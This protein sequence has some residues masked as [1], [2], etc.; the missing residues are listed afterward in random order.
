[1]VTVVKD[2]YVYF[3]TNLYLHNNNYVEYLFMRFVK[4]LPIFLLIVLWF[5]PKLGI[6]SSLSANLKG[7]WLFHQG[8]TVLSLDEIYQT[9]DWQ[10]VSTPGLINFNPANGIYGTYRYNFSLPKGFEHS[11]KPINLL[12][13]GI[14]HSDITHLNGELIGTTGYL[15]KNWD[16]LT[17]TPNNLPRLYS[18]PVGLLKQHNNELIVQIQLGFGQSFGAMLPG[19]VGISGEVNLLEANQAQQV[20]NQ[21]L[22]NIQIIDSLIILLGII[23]LAIILLLFKQTFHKFPEFKWLFL[24][25][26]LLFFGGFLLD[27]GYLQGMTGEPTKL[28]LMLS[29]LLIPLVN[30]IFFDSQQRIVSKNTI[31]FASALVILCIFLILYPQVPAEIKSLAWWF[32]NLLTL[33]FFLFALYSAILNVK[34]KRT[35]GLTMLVGFVIYLS[36]IRTQWLPFDG[37]EHR[38]IVIGSLIFRYALIWAYFLKVKELSFAYQKLS[39]RMIQEI[40]ENKK[41]IA[42]DIHDEL[43]Q[44]LASAKLQQQLVQITDD[45][46]HTVF[47]NEELKNSVQSMRRIIDG[48]HPIVLEKNTFKEALQIEANRLHKLHDIC[49]K[50]EAPE[51]EF[52]EEMNT[53][54][55]RLIQELLSNS[56]NHGQATHA[57][58]NIKIHPRKLKITVTDNG[59]GITKKTKKTQPKS[60]GFGQISLKERVHLLGGEV[61]YDKPVDNKGVKVVVTIPI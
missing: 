48:L 57:A 51:I 23:D 31:I 5:I 10:T 45:D 2:R 59:S 21:K 14:R 22:T 15:T 43:G 37:L 7:Q 28:L 34:Q 52:Q 60:N 16:L 41:A 3:F 61:H 12:F 4:N 46:K 36:L 39:S 58:V 54:L 24:S 30:A 1:M 27:F 35:G 53:N 11:S 13:E 6:A 47:L 33:L 19:G 49:I 26:T 20:F 42:R 50:I 17:D 38:N 44:H 29:I 18:I 56:I 40:E 8:D 32:W 25:S 9:T 55:F